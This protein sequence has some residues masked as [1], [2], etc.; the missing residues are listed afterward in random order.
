[1]SS[2]SRGDAQHYRQYLQF[3]KL[4]D[5]RKIER[6][7]RTAEQIKMLGVPSHY[8]VS[9]NHRNLQVTGHQHFL[10]LLWRTGI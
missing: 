5:F 2:E 3:I 8:S 4:P 6:K 10:E 9:H 7:R 1:M